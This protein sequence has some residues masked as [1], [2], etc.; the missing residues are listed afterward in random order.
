M[1][2]TRLRLHDEQQEFTPGRDL[3][4]RAIRH[5]HSVVF[6][7]L[8]KK[9]AL[10]LIKHADHFPHVAAHLHVRADDVVGLIG[11]ERLGRI[12]AE[13]DDVAPIDI[14]LLIDE[15]PFFQMHV[16]DFGVVRGD[17]FGVAAPVGLTVVVDRVVEAATPAADVRHVEDDILDRARALLDRLAVLRR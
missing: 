7:V 5:E 12:D 1:S 3:Q 15:A 9:S 10:A 14:V 16:D 17:G 4:A 13:H 6:I 2:E 8:A 11:K